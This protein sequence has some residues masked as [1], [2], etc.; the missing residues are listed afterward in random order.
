[1]SHPVAIP[2]ALW[3]SFQTWVLAMDHD[4][5]EAPHAPTQPARY[6]A[7]PRPDHIRPIEPLTTRQF[8]VLVFLS[9]GYSSKQMARELGL[10]ID[11]VKNHLR[12]LYRTLGVRDRSAAIAVAFK[13][14]ILGRPKLE[15][16]IRAE[17]QWETAQT[18]IPQHD[19][20]FEARS[21]GAA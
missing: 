6:T 11:T 12:S 4:L 21:I 7:T 18:T 9:R 13:R 8:E 10:S 1:M 15:R 3:R 20:Y 19:R 5:V 17:L 2:D 16:Q 14:G